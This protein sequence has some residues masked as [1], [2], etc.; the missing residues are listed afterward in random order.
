MVGITFMVFI[1]FMG[2]RTSPSKLT[3]VVGF[4]KKKHEQALHY[5]RTASP[6][7]LVGVKDQDVTYSSIQ[8]HQ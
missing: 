5:N 1:T 6:L 3:R 8:Q 4:D 2:D 7:K